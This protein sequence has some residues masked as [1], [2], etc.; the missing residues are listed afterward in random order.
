MGFSRQEYWS[1]LVFPSTRDLPNPEVEHGSPAVQ[2]DSL[3]TELQGK[4]FLFFFGW[5]GYIMNKSIGLSLSG[6][7]IA[8]NLELV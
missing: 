1:G 5:G 6:S 4:C 2:A 7:K 3:P 8:F